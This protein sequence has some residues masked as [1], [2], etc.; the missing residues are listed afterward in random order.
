MQNR[1]LLEL[2]KLRHYKNCMTP[3]IIIIFIIQTKKI[4]HRN[5]ETGT[6][7]LLKTL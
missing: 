6:T 2:Q 3:F 1:T 7:L 4:G 5:I